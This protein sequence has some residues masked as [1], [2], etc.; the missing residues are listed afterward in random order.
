MN[1]ILH[2][3]LEYP[4]GSLIRIRAAKASYELP[5]CETSKYNS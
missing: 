2:I 4:T 3:F 1:Y 5:A